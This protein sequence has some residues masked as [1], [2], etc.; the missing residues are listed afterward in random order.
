MSDRATEIYRWIRPYLMQDINDVVGV[1]KATATQFG[2]NLN[3][4]LLYD[5]S[6]GDYNEFAITE[7]GFSSA[8]SSA[9][10]DDVIVIPPGTITGNHTITDG[11][12]V[13]GLSRWSCIFSGQITGGDGAS[14]ETLSIERSANDS[15]TLKGVVDPASGT[16]YIR[17]CDI[18]ADQ[19]GSGDARGISIE[20][21]GIVEVWDSYIYGNSGSG[22][23]IAVYLDAGSTGTAYIYGG[24]A[25]GSTQEFNN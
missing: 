20:G 3:R 10:S 17:D 23:G 8:L 6:I 5:Q 9:G 1:K 18:E 14:I 15:S 25:E 11:V 7:S 13:V 2:V 22:T 21:S 12:K 4:I 16:F 24:R 19:S